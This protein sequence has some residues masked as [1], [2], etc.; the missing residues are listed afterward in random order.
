MKLYAG[1]YIA[2]SFMCTVEPSE[3]KVRFERPTIYKDI[4]TSGIPKRVGR[5][6]LLDLKIATFGIFRLPPPRLS[7]ALS[8]SIISLSHFT[9]HPKML[10]K[11][12]PLIATLLLA[13]LA[14]F[15]TQ[16]E[17]AKGP[18]ITHKVCLA[19]VLAPP[20]YLPTSG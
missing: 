20:S 8:V 10:N 16:A 11:L 18:V 12:L 3:P 17:A 4:K 2:D 15:A 9:T 1:Q 13:V 14:V 19:C 5:V 7:P 6:N